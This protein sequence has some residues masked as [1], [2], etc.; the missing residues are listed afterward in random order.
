M[1]SL[2][3][4]VLALAAVLSILLTT[5]GTAHADSTWSG[6]LTQA[7]DHVPIEDVAAG[8]TSSTITVTV[9]S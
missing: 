9:V 4:A 1:R 7:I 3:R 2:G 8:C 6:T 5:G